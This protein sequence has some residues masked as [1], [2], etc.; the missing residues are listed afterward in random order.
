MLRTVPTL[1]PR[2]VLRS[3]PALSRFASTASSSASSPPRPPPP[4][5]PHP[6]KPRPWEP[7]LAR[8]R[9]DY[10]HADPPSL[11]IA[12]VALHELTAIVP[13]V[14]LFA[15]FR[16]VAL[17][18]ALVAWVV[19]HSDTDDRDQSGEG[20]TPATAAAWRVT[21]RDWLKEAEDKAERVGRRYG[22]FG[23]PK[24]SRD[25][26][27]ARKAHL[28]QA[29][30]DGR[31]AVDERTSADQLR[32]S[33]DVAN[34]AAA[35]LA[36]KALIPLRILVSLR[37]SPSLANV[38]ARNFTGLRQRGK[39]YL[40]KAAPAV[41][42]G[43]AD[44]C[45]GPATRLALF[46]LI[47][48]LARRPSP[49]P[50]PPFTNHLRTR[51]HG[52]QTLRLKRLLVTHYSLL[53]P[54]PPPPPS[55]R[56]SPLRLA[57]SEH[58]LGP[59]PPLLRTT[60]FGR[61]GSGSWRRLYGRGG[62]AVEGREREAAGDS[63][64][65]TGPGALDTIE[66]LS[67]TAPAAGD[68]GDEEEK[69]GGGPRWEGEEGGGPVRLVGFSD[70]DPLNPQGWSTT[71]RTLIT[72]L[73]A[74]MCTWVG[75]CSSMNVEL[76]HQVAA[77][78]GVASE[79]TAQLDTVL[80]LVGFGVAAP[81][82]APLSELAGRTPIYL[83]SL[84]LLALFELGAA[85][86]P[87][88][89]A[90]AAL[91][92]LAGCAAT[93]PLS[94][95]GAAVGDL[96]DEDE[97]TVAFGVFGVGG[98][99]AVLLVIS[100][101]LLPETYPP[102]LLAFKAAAIRRRTRSSAYL[103]P[104]E[105]A[106]RETSFA[107]DFRRTLARPFVMLAREPIV[108]CFCA[109][110]T[111]VFIILFG[112]L[113]GYPFIFSPHSLSPGESGTLFLSIAVGL[114]L[115]AVCTPV[116]R[117]D[118]RRRVGRAHARGQAVAP[119]ERLRV[120]VVGTWAV[121]VSLYWAAWVCRPGVSIWASLGAQALFGVGIWSSFY[122]AFLYCIDSYGHKAASALAALTFLRYPIAGAAVLFTPPLYERL[123]PHLALTLLASLSLL[124]S[125]IPL[126]FYKWGARIRSWSRDAVH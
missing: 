45:S 76:A 77:D 99:A 82:W 4:T 9:H 10:P 35:Y 21:A 124:V 86:S 17:G 84:A 100:F 118:W 22:W 92:F 85:L 109:Y 87:T 51:S 117:S 71:R 3:P 62:A 19:A 126:V 57:S 122:S 65:G 78:L 46:R 20:S 89:P 54:F 88:F 24:E 70:P 106:R 83:V 67:E 12:F 29:A 69:D 39:R 93:T 42:D 30:E 1:L 41:R 32:V 31:T 60:T 18:T 110:L 75:A 102:T 81:L 63:S 25:E 47:S 8:L 6:A 115:C 107:H 7:Y 112:N 111:L 40:A 121:P 95:A 56:P 125:V 11:V 16:H 103:T 38:I 36:V 108:V 27:A 74:V 105:L 120:A 72:L 98:F 114:F 119:E 53:V 13:L 58:A 28:A 15:L 34:A 68:E 37:L 113:T 64:G 104:L 49:F 33:G 26:R 90:R 43:A 2:R 80:F 48:L 44:A 5:P 52:M 91:R 96:W 101:A 79:T 97:R 14:A 50:P 55:P 66:E 59:S 123:G 23:W 61:P 94:N 116:M 73:L